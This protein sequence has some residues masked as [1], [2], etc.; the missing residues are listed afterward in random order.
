MSELT[1]QLDEAAR[2]SWL[3]V[4]TGASSSRSKDLQ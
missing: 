4:I 2:T 1:L 3:F